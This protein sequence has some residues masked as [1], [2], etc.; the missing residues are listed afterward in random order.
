MPLNKD[1]F[2]KLAYEYAFYYGFKKR[3][4][5][6]SP[7]IAQAISSDRC[8]GFNETAVK[9]FLDFLTT[10]LEKYNFDA[11]TIYNADECGTEE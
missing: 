7:R 10:L 5:E 6:L 1:E 2:R 9:K 4:P 3:H 11:S 8:N